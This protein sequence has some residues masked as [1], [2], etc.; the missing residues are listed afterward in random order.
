MNNVY[1]D[2]VVVQEA[3]TARTET[4]TLFKWNSYKLW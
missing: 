2:T 4:S 3:R 1:V